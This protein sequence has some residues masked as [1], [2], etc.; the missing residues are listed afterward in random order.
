MPD[1]DT[2]LT[3]VRVIPATREMVWN[4]WTT[5]QELAR[6]WWPERF[7]TTYTVDLHPGRNYSFRTTDVPGMGVLALSGQFETVRPPE[8][9]IYTWHWEG[10]DELDSRVSV[11]FL[12]RADATEIH[13]RHE[14]LPTP[15]EREN[16]ITGWNDCLDRLEAYSRSEG[17]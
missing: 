5:P 11:E 1:V 6:W 3:V 17:Q 4:A 16:H 8:F 7:Q 15:E 14:G 10:N 2:T 12:A 9:L 13:I